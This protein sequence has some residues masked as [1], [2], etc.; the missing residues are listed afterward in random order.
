MTAETAAAGSL[1]GEPENGRFGRFGG[2]YVPETLVGAC[3]EVEREFRA[4]WNDPAF[5]SE[6]DGLSSVPGNLPDLRRELPPCRF[7]GRCERH[8]P[9]CDMPPLPA[10]AMGG[11]H[12][13]HCRRPL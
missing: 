8:A 1:M 11:D 2:Q 12:V 4:A 13:V 9:I 10:I 5:R 3:Q 7:S 6:L